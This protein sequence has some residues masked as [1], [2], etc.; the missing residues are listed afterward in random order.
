MRSEQQYFDDIFTLVEKIG[1]LVN[2]KTALYRWVNSKWVLLAPG[3]KLLNTYLQPAYSHY[4]YSDQPVLCQFA[5]AE[6]GGKPNALQ[7]LITSFQVAPFPGCCGLAIGTGAVVNK[8]FRNK[9]VNI[10]ANELRQAIAGYTGYTALGC[11]DK[12][13]NEFSIRTLKR[14]GFKK[15]H[16]ITNRRTRNVVN[17]Y[18]KN[19]E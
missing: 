2:V 11:T 7:N 10:V 3:E 19:L 1:E 5:V 6:V 4:R 9:G 14:N 8:D 13:N 12:A 18:V 15:L 16:S 17:L